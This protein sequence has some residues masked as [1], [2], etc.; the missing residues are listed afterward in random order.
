MSRSLNVRESY[1]GL[2][3]LANLERATFHLNTKQE[4][5][6]QPHRDAELCIYCAGRGSG[7]LGE[8]MIYCTTWCDF[9]RVRS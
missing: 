2:T 1:L 6:A 5:M 7:T 9:R 3:D 8:Q 4:F